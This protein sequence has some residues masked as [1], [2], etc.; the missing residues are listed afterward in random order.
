VEFTLTK[1]VVYL[2]RCLLVAEGDIKMANQK[3]LTLEQRIEISNLLEQNFSFKAIALKIDKD[4]T[5][6]SKEIRAHLIYKKIGCHGRNY[7]SCSSRYSCDKRSLCNECPL[8]FSKKFCW[9]C[10][11]C[12]FNCSD[13][14]N[15]T[16]YKLTKAPYVCNGC[17]ALSKCSLEKRFYKAT[18]A[19]S[20]Y[21]S[22]YSEMRTGISLSEEEVK[23]LDQIVSPLIMKGQSLNH[24]CINNRDS[25][26]ISEST[27]YRLVNY[28]VFAARNIDLARKVR[29][30]KRKLK[31]HY[32]VDKGCRIGRSYDD[33]KD[34]R[35]INPDL[36]IIEIDSVEGKKGGKVLLTIHF[37]KSEFMLAFL[38]DANDSQSVINI[39]ERLYIELSPELFTNLMPILLGDNGSE[40]SN[41]IAI[42]QDRQGNERTKL[43]Y[44]DP[45]APYQKGSAEKNHEFIRYLIPKGKSLDLFSQADITLMM[46]HINSYSRK[47]LGNKSPYDVF[48]YLYGEKTLDILGFNKIPPNEVTLRKSLFKKDLTVDDSL[49]RNLK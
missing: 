1:N 28:N 19:D 30:S 11:N 41:P 21:R 6:I 39:F 10:K 48:S 45:A 26:M 4:C 13:F 42:E 14:I 43:F 34:F 33:F 5:T 27:L 32:K 12:N 16:C 47:S 38:R 35:E 40:F 22:I 44:C 24:I 31:K 37:V 18:S 15:E 9:Q 46:N 8:V 29:Y 49:P 36:S 7:N 2:Y 25:I 3:H 23:R 17:S 20:E